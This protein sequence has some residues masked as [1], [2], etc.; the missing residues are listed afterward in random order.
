M[1]GETWNAIGQLFCLPARWQD[2]V[3]RSIIFKLTKTHVETHGSFG[4]V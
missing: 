2:S 1:S 3:L 4:D